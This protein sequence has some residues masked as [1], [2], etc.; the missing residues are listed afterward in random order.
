MKVLFA[1]SE[2]YPLIKTGGLADVAYGLP[3]ALHNGG[4]DVRLL[5]PGYQDVL[6]KLPKT[7][8][9]GQLQVLGAHGRVHTVDLL[10]AR[11]HRYP[12]PVWV[13]SCPALFYRPGNPYLDGFGQDWSDNAERF[14][15]FSRTAAQLAADALHLGWRPDVV[16][17]NDWQT[18]LIPA[19]LETV[20]PRPKSVFTI[21]NQ[22]YGGYYSH[23]V[24]N[25]LHLAWHWW[26]AEGMEFYGSFSML[27]AGI[28]YADIVT[29]VSP[30]YAKE[31][32]TPEF[33]YGMDGLL[34]SRSYKLHGILN[35]ID[36]EVWNPA[37]D[38][39]LPQN[40]SLSDFK[41]G[42]AANKRALLEQFLQ[43]EPIDEALLQR[44]LLGIVSRLV[45]QKGVDMIVD[46]IPTLLAE[47]NASFVLVGSGNHYYE[48]ALNHLATHYPGRVMVYIGYNESLAHLLEAGCDV[49][50][51]PS[52]FEPCGLNQMYSLNYASLPVVYHTGGLA[53]TVV[54]ATEDNIQQ[55]NANGFVFYTPYKDALL[56]TLRWVLDLYANQPN[57][58]QQLQNRAMQADFSWDESA[59]QYLEL[60]QA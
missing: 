43:V 27:K 60:Y 15:V 18:G 8:Y 57:L 26:S 38:P 46:S 24:F 34:R 4:V 1:A 28:A 11:D 3:H 53:D 9:L 33:G 44:P 5:L 13:V 54:N 6:H 23:E 50:L 58:W 39:Y 25:S 10:E 45:E 12:C 14:T 22:A 35:G 59:R 42:K 7:D 49:F 40:Y 17:A 19:L 29:T 55:D 30:T 36:T 2:A 37:S 16:H 52:R 56:G 20:Y 31:I 21:H 48:Q 51:M 32:A 47:S 41:S